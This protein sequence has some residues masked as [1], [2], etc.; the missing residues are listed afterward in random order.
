MRRND[1]LHQTPLGMLYGKGLYLLF[2]SGWNNAIDAQQIRDRIGIA[3][4]HQSVISL[5]YFF[6][7]N[8]CNRGPVSINFN[9][10]HALQ[11]P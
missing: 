2:F 4:K 7:R 9:Q 11:M 8:H 5:Q 10:V 6:W 1:R 3:S